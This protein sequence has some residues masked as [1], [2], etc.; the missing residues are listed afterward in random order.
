MLRLKNT[1]TLLL[2]IIL[3]MFLVAC[4]ETNTVSEES[5]G[6]TEE[7]PPVS[8]MVSAAA[9]LTEAMEEIKTAY[10][11]ENPNINITYNFAS[12]GSLQRQIEQGAEVD[13]FVSANIGK[14][15]ALSDK[16]LIIEDTKKEFLE[17]KI[18]L[19]VPKDSSIVTDFKD[20]TLDDIKVIGLGEPKSVP[21]GQYSDEILRN[22]NLLDK[23]KSKVVYGKDVKEVLTWVETG[24][25]D[26]GMVYETDSI[27]S[28]KGKVVAK[29]PEGTHSP[30]YYPAAVIKESKNVE[31]SKEFINFLYSSKAKPIFEKYGF[32]FMIK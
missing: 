11:E 23:I 10:K 26:A 32:V 18:V 20:L 6:A 16:G 3:I 29:A 1:T 7:A 5:N 22:L 8:L 13:I 30:V 25:A 31:A 17:N 21:I 2:I 24:N 14:M 19:I 4:G 28:D 9:S 15:D 27:V 12:S